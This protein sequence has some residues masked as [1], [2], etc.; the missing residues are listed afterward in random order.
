MAKVKPSLI[1]QTGTIGDR[2]YYTRFGK[3]FSRSKAT[4][5]NDNKSEAQQRQRALFK[6]MQHTSSILGSVIQRGLAK[7]AHAHGHVE[8]NEFASINKQCFTYA[9]GTVHIDYPRLI[10]STGPIARV[11]FTNCHA[12]GLHVELQFEPYIGANHAN[13]DDVVFI[14]A[15]EFQVEVCQLVACVER[16]AASVAFDLP[17]LSEETDNPIT[18]HLYAIVEA[19]NT[20]CVS[21][22][23]PDEKKADKNHRNINRRVSPSIFIGTITVGSAN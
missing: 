8:N 1:E 17:D 5:F 16:R 7:E 20:A 19:A 12:D 6:A 21:T 11:D 9:D 13:L 3:L 10:L 18:F 14:Y 4:A 15:V 23:S 22:L 2:V